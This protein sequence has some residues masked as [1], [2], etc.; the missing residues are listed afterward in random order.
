MTKTVSQPGGTSPLASE[1]DALIPAGTA[2]ATIAGDGIGVSPGE[3]R[4]TFSVTREYPLVSIVTMIAPSPD[5]FLGETG[6]SLLA[7]GTSIG[8][9]A[10]DLLPCDAGT[11][12]GTTYTSTNEPPASP[13]AVRRI[14]IAPLLAG[15]T[16]LS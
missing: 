15:G 6:L 3:V 2:C 9:L 12:S 1:I 14:E 7:M 10:V 16:A 13:E 11:D 8:C 4:V 5:W